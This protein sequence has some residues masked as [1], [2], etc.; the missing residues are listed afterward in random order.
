[1]KVEIEFLH[2]LQG[3]HNPVV[4]RIMLFIT[5]LG[6]GNFIWLLIS[7]FMILMPPIRQL[8]NK[9]CDE[10][11]LVAVRRRKN[12]GATVIISLILSII[13]VNLC[14]KPFFGRLRPFQV[15]S[16]LELDNGSLSVQNLK[17]SS[18]PSGHTSAAFAAAIA[19]FL[20]K[21][22]M[23]IVAITLASL[24]AFSRMYFLVHFPTDILG[25]MISGI[26]CGKVGK[27]LANKWIVKL[28]NKKSST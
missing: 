3:F 24:I 25:G 14:M 12:A 17:D 28:D 27:L 19:I 8:M 15:D 16:T 9:E 26:I 22:K 4:D 13:L 10:E 20:S 7:A 2:V 23:G 21:K 1:M 11:Y 18:F 5:K 6:D